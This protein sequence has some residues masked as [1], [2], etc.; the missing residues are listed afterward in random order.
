MSSSPRS[1]PSQ[2]AVFA[3]AVG[4]LLIGAVI[5]AIAIGINL[6]QVGQTFLT[7]LYPPIAVTEQGEQIRI[8]YTIVFVIAV[9]VFLVVEGLIIGRSSAIAGSRATT[10]SHRRRTATTSPNSS[11][12]SSRP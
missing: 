2:T 9:A 3:L 4:A 11:G 5:I 6:I 12:R 8:L 7:G 1:G 10:P